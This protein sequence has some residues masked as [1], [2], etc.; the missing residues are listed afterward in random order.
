MKRSVQNSLLARQAPDEGQRVQ[1]PKRFYNNNNKGED[2]N[3]NSP[4]PEMGL[5]ADLWELNAWKM[6]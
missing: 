2:D 1:G 4:P 3:A 5:D 6:R